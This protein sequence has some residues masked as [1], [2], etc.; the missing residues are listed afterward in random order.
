MW[1]LQTSLKSLYLFSEKEIH[2]TIDQPYLVIINYRDL[3]CIFQSYDSEKE[4]PGWDCKPGLEVSL[5]PHWIVSGRIS[6][7]AI[8]LKIAGGVERIYLCGGVSG[9]RHFYCE[10]HQSLL[11]SNKRGGSV[12]QITWMSKTI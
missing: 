2:E 10:G 1:N 11:Q 5:L 7:H 6:Y 8:I 4:D 3:L 9:D 12:N